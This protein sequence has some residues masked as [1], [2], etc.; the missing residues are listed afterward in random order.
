MHQNDWDNSW[1]HRLWSNGGLRQIDFLL[2][3]ETRRH[4]AQEAG[5]I[6]A[7]DGKSDHRGVFSLL[8]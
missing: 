4:C 1:T 3:D 6:H 5:I 8:S 2:T 7:L